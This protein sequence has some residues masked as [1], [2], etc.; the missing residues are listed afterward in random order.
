MKDERRKAESGNLR[1][2]R[3]RKKVSRKGRGGKCGNRKFEI[4]KRRFW[5]VFIGLFLCGLGELGARFGFMEMPF[6]T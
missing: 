3:S 2:E 4:G 5:L 1:A 6:F